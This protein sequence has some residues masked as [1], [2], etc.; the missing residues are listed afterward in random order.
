M[1][2]RTLGNNVFASCFRLK[3]L[4]LPEGLERIEVACFEA[5]GL[6]TVAVPASVTEIEDRAFCHCRALR[7]V[8]FE[9]DSKIRSIGANAFAGTAL[10][11][12]VAPASLRSI[13]GAAF[14][15]CEKLASVKLNAGIQKI[16]LFCFSGTCVKTVALPE[17]ITMNPDELGLGCN[18][19]KVIV[20][21]ECAE[22]VQS[23][24]VETGGATAV[25]VPRGVRELGE[26]LFRE[27]PALRWLVF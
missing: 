16:G 18:Y 11:G 26:F 6:E 5:S 14:C 7:S 4:W 19:T 12:F 20:L 10:T 25:V 13:G 23:C 15:G 3:S 9:E 1:G 17:T 2:L 8:T 27:S 22:R 24:D 21:P